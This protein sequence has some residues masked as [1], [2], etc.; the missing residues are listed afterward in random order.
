VRQWLE[1]VGS[2][3]V[4]RV[5]Q[6]WLPDEQAAFT[7]EREGHP[8]ETVTTAGHDQIACMLDDFSRAVLEK[9]QVRPPPEEA[10]K[11]LRVLDALARSARE[12][13]EID[14]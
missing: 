3:G 6:M 1:I 12:G 5:T 11:T 14:V 13:R 9:S 4:I 7:I 8:P 10:V 2:G